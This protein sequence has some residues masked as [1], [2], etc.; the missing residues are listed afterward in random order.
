MHLGRQHLLPWEETGVGQ[1]EKSD[2]GGVLRGREVPLRSGQQD[3]LTLRLMRS[4]A[5]FLLS[6]NA[7]SLCPWNWEDGLLGNHF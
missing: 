4:R 6:Q 3:I 7:N 1:A 2:P 5:L